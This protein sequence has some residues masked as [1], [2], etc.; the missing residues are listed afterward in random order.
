MSGRDVRPYLLEPGSLTAVLQ[1]LA[2]HHQKSFQ[3]I[4][5]QSITLATS[6]EARNLKLRQRSQL[7]KREVFLMGDTQAWVFAQSLIPLDD[8]RGS[9]QSLAGIGSKPLGAI[10]FSN[11]RVKRDPHT[12]KKVLVSQ[13]LCKKWSLAPSLQGKTLWAR[14]AIFSINQARLSVTEIFLPELLALK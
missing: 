10:L 2:Y 14:R 12:Y 9:W 6:S 1:A 11:P 5:S 7:L 8:L 4:P 3:V 13:K